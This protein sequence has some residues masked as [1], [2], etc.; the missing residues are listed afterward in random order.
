[1][2]GNFVC[3][4]YV[5]YNYCEVMMMF[6]IKGLC[7]IVVGF[8]VCGFYLVSVMGEVLIKFSFI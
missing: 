2:V 7:Y 4:I 8:F 3:L 6:F 1:M 5:K